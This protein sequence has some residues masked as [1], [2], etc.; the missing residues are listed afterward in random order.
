MRT[1]NVH[2]IHHVNVNQFMIMNASVKRARVHAHGRP[3]TVYTVPRA[4]GGQ[5]KALQLTSCNVYCFVRVYTYVRAR[6]TY[7]YIRATVLVLLACTVVRA[8]TPVPVEF[9]RVRM[10][11]VTSSRP[12]PRCRCTRPA[13][14]RPM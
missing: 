4:V 11:M 6:R 12:R 5:A 1:Q 7:V 2:D 13:I 9:E 14:A 3:V 10:L 8:G